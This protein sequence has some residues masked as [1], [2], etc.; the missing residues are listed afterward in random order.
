MKHLLVLAFAALSLS[1][2]QDRRTFSGVIND[3]MCARSG[4][5]SMRMGPTDAEC[6]RACVMLHGALYVLADGATVYY[7]SDQ[8]TPDAFAGQ[9]VSVVGT[10]NAKTSTIQVDSITAAQ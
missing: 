8:H 6:T 2:A 4:H 5:G 3:D 10:L 1:A 9:K 7:L